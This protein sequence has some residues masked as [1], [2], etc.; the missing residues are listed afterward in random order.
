M[1]TL[2]SLLSA[3][4]LLLISA[5][6]SS[7]DNSHKNSNPNTTTHAIIGNWRLQD[8][9]DVSARSPASYRDFTL[10]VDLDQI[11]GSAANY[12]S[13]PVFID[14]N[15]ISVSSQFTHS[16]KMAM[17]ETGKMEK[18]YFACLIHAERWQ[19]KGSQLL[20]EGS[21]GRLVFQRDF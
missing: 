3:L 14:S 8:M 15:Q 2:R 18:Y 1:K 13:A 19:V 7:T 17:G 10:R 21:K 6:A 9:P 20:L 16:R 5:C 4:T 12:F 11:R